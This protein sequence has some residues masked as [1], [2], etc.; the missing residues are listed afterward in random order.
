MCASKKTI[1]AD[2][3]LVEKNLAESRSKAQ[4]MI[5]ARQVRLS[6][7]D[8]IDKPSRKIPIDSELI[9]THTQKYVS[10]GGEKLDGFLS[11]FNITVENKK[12]LDIGASTG[13]FT[14]CLL[15]H[16]AAHV[17][18]IDVGHGQLHYKLQND[19]RVSNHENTHVK[20]LTHEFFN[21]QL[22]DV[23][24]CDVSFISLKKV[25]PIIW[26]FIAENGIL[27]AL[28][29]P[30]FEADKVY[31]NQCKGVIRDAN[32]QEKI[33][34]EIVAFARE[35]LSLSNLIGVID[36]PIKGTDGNR[37]FLFGIKN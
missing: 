11:Q 1:R 2:E 14:D 16:G 5:L 13:G 27:V 37:E 12:C 26:E 28:I 17:T 9:V 23:I 18:C 34:D 32:I 36:S 3:L 15:Q 7:D 21:N 24:V 30:Q 31:M 29:K 8:V 6:S 22:F 19:P 10:R 33:R 35:N 25:L 4:A 20:T